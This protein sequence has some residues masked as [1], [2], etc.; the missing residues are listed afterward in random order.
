[1]SIVLTKENFDSTI[2]ENSQPVLVDFWATWCG[3]CKML[4]PVIEEIAADYEDKAV[5]GKVN[6]DNDVEIAEKFGIMSIPAVF[7]FKDGE[8][9]DKMIGFRKKE[10]IAAV[11]DKYI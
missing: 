11:L 3:P 10:Q 8:V 5:I 1:M 7:I 9:V 2:V 6:V 4:G